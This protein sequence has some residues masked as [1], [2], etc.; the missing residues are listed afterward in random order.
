MG[1]PVKTLF[2]TTWAFIQQRD[3]SKGT[4]TD[5][6]PEPSFQTGPV[7]VWILTSFAF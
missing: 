7:D 6:D 2:V 3:T 1:F 4:D 5:S